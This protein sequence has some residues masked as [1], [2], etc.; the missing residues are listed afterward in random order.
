MQEQP[1]V[2]QV[3]FSYISYDLDLDLMCLVSCEDYN[4][5]FCSIFDFN[6]FVSCLD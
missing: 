4:L 1:S 2:S 3:I 6:L 5:V